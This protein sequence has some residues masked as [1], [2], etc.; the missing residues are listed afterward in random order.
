MA[1][2]GS[3]HSEKVVD[4]AC[5]LAK[6]LSTGIVLL[7]VVKLPGEPESVAAYSKAENNPDAYAD[8]LKEFMEKSAEK[9]SKMIE[10]T[11]I[12]FKSIVGSG[13]PAQTILETAK[14]EN[15]SVIVVGLTGLHGLGRIRS[16]GSVARRVLENSSIPVIVVP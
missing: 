6:Q 3:K 10:V 4:Y 12:P 1:V 11:G 15:A 7:S 2:D 13:N 16:L 14:L 8:Y 5:N 9:F